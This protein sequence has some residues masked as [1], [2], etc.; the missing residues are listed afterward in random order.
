MYVVFSLQ[1][2]AFSLVKSRLALRSPGWLFG[3]LSPCQNGLTHSNMVVDCPILIVH[4]AFS[5]WPQILAGINCKQVT[6]AKSVSRRVVFYWI[7]SLFFRLLLNS[8]SFVF[9]PPYA[10]DDCAHG[11]WTAF[12]CFTFVFFPSLKNNRIPSWQNLSWYASQVLNL[13]SSQH[14]FSLQCSS[15]LRCVCTLCHP[16]VPPPPPA[17]EK[18]KQ[19]H[20][21][22]CKNN[23]RN[24][25]KS[26][27]SSDKLF[28]ARGSDFCGH[29]L[30]EMSK[31]KAIENQI[32]RFERTTLLS[33]F[34][35]R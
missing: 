29:I 24:Q 10:V 25:E 21:H 17:A 1:K 30:Y 22:S 6:T 34:G 26:G 2:T 11:H 28:Q 12:C 33:C 15:H 8:V 31:S 18:R 23:K 16:P 3:C 20:H 7:L 13:F 5:Q 35:W 27:Y 19:R 9:S 4:F 32:H 14:I